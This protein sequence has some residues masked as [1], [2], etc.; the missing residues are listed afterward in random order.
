VHF[1]THIK[2]C[3]VW[4]TLP[5]EFLFDNRCS[6]DCSQLYFDHAMCCRMFHG[7]NDKP[8]VL[9]PI[10]RDAEKGWFDVARCNDCIAV[11]GPSGDAPSTWSNESVLVNE[12]DLALRRKAQT[13]GEVV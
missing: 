5:V 7:D 3:W 6:E 9:Q 4:V 10:V 13:A 1:Y 11:F 2:G 12:D 8:I